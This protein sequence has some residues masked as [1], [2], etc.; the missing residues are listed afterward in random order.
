LRREPEDHRRGRG[1]HS[2]NPSREHL[3]EELGTGLAKRRAEVISLLFRQSRKG[4]VAAIKR[5]EEMTSVASSLAN[6]KSPKE[7]R[8][9]KKETLQ[10]AALTDSEGTGWEELLA[11]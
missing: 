3:S 9:G 7:P 1:H 2:A 6:P 10:R 4:N 8:L 5:L 11:P